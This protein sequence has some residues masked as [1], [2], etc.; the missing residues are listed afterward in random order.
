MLF[1]AAMPRSGG[2]KSKPSMLETRYEMLL[3]PGATIDSDS[4]SEDDEEGGGAKLKYAAFLR[5]VI[6]RGF[7]F[8]NKQ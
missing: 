2:K 8:T 5:S 3:K 7:F 6:M 4:G 1:V